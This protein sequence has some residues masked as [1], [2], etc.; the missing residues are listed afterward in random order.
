MAG[1]QPVVDS[2]LRVRGVSGLRVVDG[3]VMP[4][5]TSGNTQAACYVIGEK[6]ADM[7]LGKL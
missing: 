6:A 2:D 1:E 3:S 4:T 7:I 5:V